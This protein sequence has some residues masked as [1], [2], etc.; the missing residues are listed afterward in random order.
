MPASQTRAELEDTSAEGDKQVGSSV[1]VLPNMHPR[2]CELLTS[3]FVGGGLHLLSLMCCRPF[4][5]LLL[6]SCS[7]L[8]RFLTL[9]TA[10]PALLLP[11]TDF[12][13]MLGRMRFEALPCGL[14]RRRRLLALSCSA[15]CSAAFI[16]QPAAPLPKP[17]L[18]LSARPSY[19]MLACHRECCEALSD[20]SWLPQSS[21][22]N[23]AV[24]ATL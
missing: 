14:L 1:P 20:S 5:P 8:Q 9:R 24:S 4:Q 3:G 12:F 17:F 18:I 11:A 23:L 19:F 7:T 16:V 13:L 2:L 22:P 15:I 6:H 10:V 21:S